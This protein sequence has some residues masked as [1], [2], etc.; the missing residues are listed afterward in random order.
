MFKVQCSTVV[1]M[2]QVQFTIQTVS[3]KEHSSS[4]LCFGYIVL[5]IFAHQQEIEKRRDKLK[6][7]R[8]EKI[9]LKETLAI[10]LK[11]NQIFHNG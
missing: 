7:K 2:L 9:K 1:T 10:V 11:E 8:K 6:E 4:Q 5:R 3:S